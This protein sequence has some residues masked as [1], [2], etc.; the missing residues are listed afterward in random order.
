MAQDLVE[1]VEERGEVVVRGPYPKMRG[2]LTYLKGQGFNYTAD[3]SWRIPLVRL[4]PLKRKNLQKRVDGVN[5][6]QEAPP[7]VEDRVARMAEVQSLFQ[8]A[9]RIRYEGLLFIPS[10]DRNGVSLTGEISPLKDF[11]LKAG[12]KYNETSSRFELENTSPSG[13]RA[14]LSECSKLSDQVAKI[15]SEVSRKLPK[16]FKTLGIS[17]S[18]INNRTLQVVG[19]TFDLRDEIKRILKKPTFVGS[20]KS[21][22]IPLHSVT[23]SQVYELL[24]YLG[25]K[26][27]E[28][29]EKWKEVPTKRDPIPQVRDRKVPNRKGDFCVVCGAWCAPGDGFLVSR[30][31]DEDGDFV[32]KVQHRDPQDCEK[33]KIESQRIRE[34][35]RVIQEKA[36]TKQEAR[37]S[38][39]NLCAKPEN[40]GPDRKDAPPGE[41]IW[42][43][44]SS[45]N[46]GGGTWVIL[47]PNG[48]YLWY[49]RGNSADGD[50][51]SYNNVAGHAIGY[52]LPLTEE[53]KT[54]LEVAK[55]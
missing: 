27:A 55:E 2:L 43:D 50:N 1:V 40:L 10:Q 6:P 46:Y 20:N 3:R 22:V 9:N 12:G 39:A 31:D 18:L 17:V 36:R 23:E 48:D 7:S 19:K 16:K 32:T 5:G 35:A 51:W 13:F 4:T 29:E 21:W 41:K 28:A 37:R 15:L 47:E 53:I 8:E 52:R 42:V 44:S 34:E 24:T 33:G 49:L 14:L 26:E 45:S 38:L 25:E 54:I 30:Y 11:I